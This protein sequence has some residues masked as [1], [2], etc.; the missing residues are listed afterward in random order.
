MSGIGVCAVAPER[1]DLHTP[2]AGE[3][4]HRSM[5]DACGNGSREHLHYLL[6]CGIGCDV[7]IV[8]GSSNEEVPYGT[9]NHPGLETMVVEFLSYVVNVYGNFHL[10]R[11]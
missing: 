8:G 1:C 11:K 4:G 7:V 10:R 9:A 5:L 2:V 6:G 3:H